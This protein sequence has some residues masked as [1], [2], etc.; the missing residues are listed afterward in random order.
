MNW[1]LLHNML[2]INDGHTLKAAKVLLQTDMTS[3]SVSAY[4]G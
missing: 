2:K 4:Q 1:I 3:S